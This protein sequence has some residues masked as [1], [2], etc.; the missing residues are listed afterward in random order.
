MVTKILTQFYTQR[1]KSGSARVAHNKSLVEILSARHGSLNKSFF[2]LKLLS[3]IKQNA[4]KTS[5]LSTSSSEFR[6]KL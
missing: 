5:C 6:L 2:V 1:G 4:M 3:A